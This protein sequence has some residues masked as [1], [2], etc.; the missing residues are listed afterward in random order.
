MGE[1]GGKT[2]SKTKLR[3]IPC[4]ANR[5]HRVR[6][7]LEPGQGQGHGS[8]QQGFRK[9]PGGSSW[10]KMLAGKKGLGNPA[11][12]PK[13]LSWLGKKPP[14]GTSPPTPPPPMRPL[15]RPGAQGRGKP[16]REEFMLISIS[17]AEKNAFHFHPISAEFSRNPWGGAGFELLGK[18]RTGRRSAAPLADPLTQTSSQTFFVTRNGGSLTTR[19]SSKNQ[20]N[21]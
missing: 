13:P 11:Q 14:G 9:D 2:R 19:N 8:G 16:K 3:G 6:V 7:W 17:R 21:K 15:A 18:N 4:V 12:R 5:I 10:K 1:L 20:I